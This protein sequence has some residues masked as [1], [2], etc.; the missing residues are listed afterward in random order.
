MNYTYT[1]EKKVVR[2]GPPLNRVD[3]EFF[4]QPS[5]ELFNF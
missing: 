2:D 1:Y 5:H 4:S 3:S